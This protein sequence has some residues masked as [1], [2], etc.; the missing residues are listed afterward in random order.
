MTAAAGLGV[1][2][3]AQAA[4]CSGAHGVTVVVDF[5][6]LGGGAQSA[7]DANGSGKT[8]LTQLKDV[9]HQLT[10]V[11]RQPGFV[12][13]VDGAP[14][15]DP[16][17]NTPPSDAYWSLWWSDGKSGKWVYSSSGAASLQVPDGGYVALSWQ[18]GDG[19]AA[20][21]VTPTAHASASPT[22]SPTPR[23]SSTPN[24]S[25][26]PNPSSTPTRHGSSSPAGGATSSPTTSSPAATSSRSPRPPHPSASAPAARQHA[27]KTPTATPTAAPTDLP[28]TTNAAEPL[29]RAA[30]DSD[31]GLPG[32]VAPVLVGALFVAA[33]AVAFVRRKRAGG[34]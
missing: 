31:A 16:C 23:P 3:P 8:A 33:G 4:S 9:G 34:A 20:P 32:W 14:A 11:Q 22:A 5:H 12:C 18:G 15:S 24:P 28:A 19:K 1:P 10:Y 17:V 27:G 29:D 7:C 6:E 2:A 25:S 13:R 26:S 21:G 30:A